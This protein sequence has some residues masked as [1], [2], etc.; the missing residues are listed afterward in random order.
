MKKNWLLWGAVAVGAYL[1]YKRMNKDT[2]KELAPPPV[3][4]TR[5]PSTFG[6][7]PKNTSPAKAKVQGLPSG[8]ECPSKDMLATRRYSRLEMEQL[9][10]YGCLDN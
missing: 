9:R 5:P 7:P 6:K 10:V 2:G 1:I 8:Y 3:G 4:N